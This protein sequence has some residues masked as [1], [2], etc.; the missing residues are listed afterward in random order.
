[1][2]DLD[3]RQMAGQHP[4]AV[5]RPLGRAG[6]ARG[7]DQ[8]RRILGPGVAGGER[9]VIKRQR[10]GHDLH[11]AA[12]QPDPQRVGAG[13][14][15]NHQPHPG[16]NQ[17]GDQRIGAE[18]G[19]QRDRDRPQLPDRDMRRRRPRALR[20]QHPDPVARPDPLPRQMARQPVGHGAQATIA[21]L[22]PLPA[23]QINQ[24]QPV[25]LALSPGVTDLHCHVQPGRNVPAKACDESVIAG[26]GDQHVTPP[27]PSV[28]ARSASA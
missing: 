27:P 24:R 12:G 17:P 11:A 1:M 23:G 14:V 2:A 4:V 7:V 19:E 8:H 10:L 5:Q 28:P 13:R 3:P 18:Q 22:D 21:D 15:G 26:G 20:A 16:V 25:G 6:G 9:A